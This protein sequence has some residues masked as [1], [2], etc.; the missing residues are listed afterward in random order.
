MYNGAINVGG[1]VIPANQNQTESIIPQGGR[2]EAVHDA[3]S[4]SAGLRP[5]NS[6]AAGTLCYN[7]W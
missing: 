2:F 5:V 7:L 6:G 4:W 3:P 1:C